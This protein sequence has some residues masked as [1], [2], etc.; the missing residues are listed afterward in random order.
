M[1]PTSILLLT[2]TILAT[3]GPLYAQVQSPSPAATATPVAYEPLPT[4]DASV[5]L[6]PQ[7]FHGPNFRVRNA[8]PTY[9]GSNHYT[10]AQDLSWRGKRRGYPAGVSAA[11]ARARS[12]TGRQEERRP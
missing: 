9:F 8:V 11:A 3:T 1:K 12:T 2:A 7:Y 4:L 6:Q 10:I 5:I